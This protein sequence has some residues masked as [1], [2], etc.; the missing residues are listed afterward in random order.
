MISQPFDC[1]DATKISVAVVDVVTEAPDMDVFRGVNV[2]DL[3]MYWPMVDLRSSHA[4]MRKN[5][6]R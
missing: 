1:G 6:P 4:T 5:T 3:Y 2:A